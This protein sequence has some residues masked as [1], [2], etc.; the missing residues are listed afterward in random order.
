MRGRFDQGAVGIERGD[1]G[2][3]VLGCRRIS[4]Q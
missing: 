4:T 3:L 1:C 2:G